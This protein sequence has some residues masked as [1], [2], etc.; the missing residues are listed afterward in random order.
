MG[1]QFGARFATRFVAEHAVLRFANHEITAQQ[2]VAIA[3]GFLLHVPTIGAPMLVASGALEGAPWR[4]LLGLIACAALLALGVLPGGS[5]M[6][7]TARGGE[8]AGGGG[9]PRAAKATVGS[10][11]LGGGLP[12]EIGLLLHYELLTTLRQPQRLMSIIIAPLVGVLF[13]V[14]GHG[15]V[16]VGAMFVL[17]MLA[18]GRQQLRA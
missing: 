3:G 14:N 5:L 13:F 12:R 16:N 6:R 10:F 18:H 4:A 2:A 11:A 9:R 15:R 17:I 8:S 7:R 1:L